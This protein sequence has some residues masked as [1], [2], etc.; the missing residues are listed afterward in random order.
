MTSITPSATPPAA[1]MTPAAA[2]AA[3]TSK[4]SVLTQVKDFF[5]QKLGLS[6]IAAPAQDA[7]KPADFNRAFAAMLRDSFKGADHIAEKIEAQF[8]KKLSD[9]E[10]RAILKEA[11]QGHPIASMSF[12]VPPSATK[13]FHLSPAALP[14]SLANTPRL[15]AKIQDKIN[16]GA[17][18]VQSLQTEGVDPKAKPTK[19]DVANVMWFLQATA[20]NK[21]GQSFKSGAVTIED[22]GGALR[23]W[24]DKCPDAYQ[25]GSSHVKGFQKMPEGTQRGIDMTAQGEDVDTLLPNERKTVLY[26]RLAQNHDPKKGP[27]MPT[28]M[29]FIKLESHGCK[30][31]QRALPFLQDS[32]APKAPKLL[33]SHDIKESILH[34]CSFLEGSAAR[35]SGDHGADT[36]KERVPKAAIEG[37]NFLLEHMPES[38]RA[39]L[40]NLDPKDKSAGIRVMKANIDAVEA[41]FD[42]P[43][44]GAAD[45]QSAK[46]LVN[47]FRED[48]IAKYDADTIDLRIG[49]EVILTRGDVMGT[50]QQKEAQAARALNG[51]I[52]R[53][54]DA[55]RTGEAE[56][57]KTLMAA[58]AKDEAAFSKLG[59]FEQ[60]PRQR[61]DTQLK[62]LSS[63]E[64]DKAG[65]AASKLGY[66]MIEREVANAIK[67]ARA[68]RLFTG[69]ALHSAAVQLKNHVEQ[70]P[71]TTGVDQAL[72]DIFN[73]AVK[74]IGSKYDAG[75]GQAQ[76]DVQARL[77]FN[78]L[79]NLPATDRAQILPRLDMTI[80]SGLSKIDP[81]P[82][83]A[84]IS[85]DIAS[86]ARQRMSDIETR[87]ANIVDPVLRQTDTLKTAPAT[88][89]KAL[90]AAEELG[91][92]AYDFKTALGISD[93]PVTDKIAQLHSALQTQETP[94]FKTLDA[95]QI[96]ELGTLTATLFRLGGKTEDALPGAFRDAYRDRLA[97]GD[98]ALTRDVATVIGRI[99]ATPSAFLDA[100]GALGK[101][102]SDRDFVLRSLRGRD[103]DIDTSADEADAAMARA[104]AKLSLEQAQESYEA[105]NTPEIR[106]FRG[107]LNYVSEEMVVNPSF[108]DMP[109]TAGPI[110]AALNVL[111]QCLGDRSRAETSI[112]HDY[113]TPP[114]DPAAPGLSDDMIAAFRNLGYDF[115]TGGPFTGQA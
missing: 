83:G 53:L 72:M 84:E 37:Y 26:G 15:E 115:P 89:A 111:E 33:S 71:S 114:F 9:C 81:G 61:L 110:V 16:L 38:L 77:M 24:L 3:T 55:L 90:N 58:V 14:L 62:S 99:D 80:L 27:V 12:S 54:L 86:E 74:P 106:N 48:V 85:S 6:K 50:G 41:K 31:N 94:D 52:S 21:A 66:S 23:Q 88:F 113:P 100:V 18:L 68:E 98:A 65:K 76:K 5:V 51:S 17:A 43:K 79:E 69:P 22:P 34:A 97:Q 87:L 78:I 32:N 7:V 102:A 2:P 42:D 109:N 19:E 63:E 20:E 64:L 104:V 35:K 10:C 101:S 28:E 103:L 30:L 75:F 93:K 36:R 92:I 112:I 4:G 29:L 107:A 67:S 46:F 44:V 45:Y 47:K 1:P 60:T 73:S 8:D 59:P 105:I 82:A 39:P 70:T 91:N 11:R 40:L 25:R 56:D 95:L 108:T 96:D 49:N 13:G 57:L